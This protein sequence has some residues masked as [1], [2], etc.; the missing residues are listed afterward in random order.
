MARYSGTTLSRD[1]KITSLDRGC[2]VSFGMYDFGLVERQPKLNLDPPPRFFTGLSQD[3]E[4]SSD[5]MPSSSGRTVSAFPKIQA[6]IDGFIR[7]S[8]R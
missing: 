3:E 5:V 6:D 8:S 4:V 2:T 1:N 7:L